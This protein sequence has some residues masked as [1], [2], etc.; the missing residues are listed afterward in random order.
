MPTPTP[1]VAAVATTHPGPCTDACPPLLRALA[2]QAH[3]HARRAGQALAALWGHASR[4]A[5][6][7]P[8]QRRAHGTRQRTDALLGF[9]LTASS[10]QHQR[11]MSWQ[12]NWLVFCD[13]GSCSHPSTHN[14]VP[15]TN[16]L[17]MP[18][19]AIYPS[20][21]IQALALQLPRGLRCESPRHTRSARAPGTCAASPHLAC[22]NTP[23]LVQARSSPCRTL[24]WSQ[25]Q[26]TVPAAPAAAGQ[27]WQ[28][29]TWG[30]SGGQTSN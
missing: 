11:T 27:G 28:K 12:V 29:H 21:L 4:Q 24:G 22:W 25:M 16:P 13:G 26:R 8:P 18:D 5:G 14:L 1:T 2:K 20:A 10:G 15:A 6:G 19:T 9:G 23:Q 17:Q 30:I 3:A 7:R